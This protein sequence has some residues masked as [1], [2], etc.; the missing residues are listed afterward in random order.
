[1]HFG[2]NL[3]SVSEASEHSPAVPVSLV[4]HRHDVHGDVILLVRVQ[5]CY[6]H[7]HGGKHPPERGEKQHIINAMETISF[8]PFTL[9]KLTAGDKI[10]PKFPPQQPSGDSETCSCHMAD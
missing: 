6:L 9:C 8:Y 3:I 1:M 5:T 2:I 4:V 7:P 10:G